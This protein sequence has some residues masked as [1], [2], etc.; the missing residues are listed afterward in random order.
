MNVLMR[1]N[2]QAVARFADPTAVLA[3]VVAS[4]PHPAWTGLSVGW[5]VMKEKAP[6]YS[7]VHLAFGH[8][9]SGHRLKSPSAPP[10]SR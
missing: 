6:R 3:A 5:L 2:G 10:G 8:T 4:G 7:V 1:L 9:G